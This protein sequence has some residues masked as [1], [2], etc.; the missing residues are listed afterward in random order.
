MLTLCSLLNLYLLQI[1]SVASSSTLDLPTSTSQWFF[2][3]EHANVHKTYIYLQLETN[4]SKILI[5]SLIL[6]PPNI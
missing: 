4:E 2:K 6:L 3:N 5:L 1:I